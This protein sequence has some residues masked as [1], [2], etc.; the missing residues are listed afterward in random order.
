MLHQHTETLD[1]ALGAGQVTGYAGFDPSA[2]SLHVGHLIP[3]MGLAHLQ[4]AGHRPII[5]VG[6]G[7][8]MIGDPSGRSAERQLH[9]PDQVE[10]NS[11]ALRRQLERFLD[12]EGPTAARLM[13][14][15]EWLLPLD[16]ITFMRDVGKHFTI[17]YM[18]AKDSVKS[19]IDAGISYTEFSY[20]LLQAYD[21]LELH[22]RAGVTLQLGGSDQWGNI[23]A[24]MELIRRTVGAD[25]HALTLQLLLNASGTKF[26][27]SEGGNVWLDPELTS[28][29]RFYQFWINAD[30]R[31][32]G[33][34]LRYFTLLSRAEIEALDRM[35]TESPEQR[36]AQTRL[37]QEVTA[38]V[39][40]E[41]AARTAAEVSAFIFGS[42]DPA[43][44]SATALRLLRA[45]APFSEIAEPDLVGAPVGESGGAVRYDVLKL[46]TIAGIAAS[47]GAAKR[48]LEQGGVSVNRRKLGA[49]ER[50]V[51]P[52]SVL[53]A[54]DHL[55]IAKGKK[56]YALVRVVR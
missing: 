23:T 11:R 12:F 29:Y 9:S 13:N 35:V 56:E 44:L 41:E 50:F 45:E 37:A 19:R 46:L 24:G 30:D 53:L 5:L 55:I 18:L 25:A 39:H 26:G 7:T 52:A 6:G 33:R 43:Q 22:R 47:N 54:G 36:G 32:V 34:Y 3:V 15:A 27:K 4:R 48:L 49:S 40:G 51:D 31:D 10:A 2:S 42:L 28:P 1:D 17:N 14:N 20:M 21:Y 16:A 8:G 38:Q